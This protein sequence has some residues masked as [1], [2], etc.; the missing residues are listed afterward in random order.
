MWLDYPEYT[1]VASYYLLK[2][3]RDLSDSDTLTDNQ[4]PPLS[5]KGWCLLTIYVELHPFYLVAQFAE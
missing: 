1:H 2:K 5:V 3:R 4:Q